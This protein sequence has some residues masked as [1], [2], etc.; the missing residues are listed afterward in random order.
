MKIKASPYWTNQKI[1]IKEKRKMERERKIN[2]MCRWSLL[3]AGLIALFWTIW[4]LATGSVP[5]SKGITMTSGWT[6]GFPFRISRWW[7][8][9][10][11]P[12]CSMILIFSLTNEKIEKE[13]K[14]SFGLVI[15]VVSALSFGVTFA[16]VGL[17]SGLVFGLISALVFTLA[18]ALVIGLIYL[19]KCVFSRDFWSAIGKW[20]IAKE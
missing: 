1:Q 9:L 5:V 13:G 11:G 8:I 16:L 18:V 6:L 15:A 7:D 20:L 2:L 4:Y 3:T 17:V 14:P 10:I 19:L 12:T